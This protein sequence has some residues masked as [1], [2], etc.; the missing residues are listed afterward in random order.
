MTNLFP[1]PLVASN[2]QAGYQAPQLANTLVVYRLA[3]ADFAG[4]EAALQL[5]LTDAELQHAQR[6]ARPAD[7]LRFRVGRGCLRYLLGQRLGRLPAAIE[8]RTGR[9]GKPQLAEPAGVHFNVAH[10]GDWVVV[11]LAAREIGIDLEQMVPDFDF[12]E[13]AA[14]RF[15]PAEQ[16]QLTLSPEPQLAF[17]HI[18]TQLEA[19]AKAS[20]LGLG[21]EALRPASSGPPAQWTV[22]NFG[23]LPGHPGAVA[24]P[25]DWQPVIQFRSLDPRL[26]A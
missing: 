5:L 25:A 1:T 11:A 3:V 4:R 2:L 10:S 9:F 19:R 20:G 16:L 26:I 13:V 24:Y 7:Q 15:S 8:L 12:A 18:W 17:Y 23:L 22:Q 21:D 14:Q 6:Y